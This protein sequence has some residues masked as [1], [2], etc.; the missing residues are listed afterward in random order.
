MGGSERTSSEDAPPPVSATFALASQDYKEFVEEHR[1]ART[2]SAAARARSRRRSSSG[3]PPK[4]LPSG[5]AKLTKLAQKKRFLLKAAGSGGDVVARLG[6]L[7]AALLCELGAASG[8]AAAA[9]AR[10]SAIDFID[11]EVQTL[12]GLNIN[13]FYSSALKLNC[14]NNLFKRAKTNCM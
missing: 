14:I 6:A 7:K 11:G 5:Y 4:A 9:R 8:S 13:T 2:R 3:H 1:S 10:Q 12:L